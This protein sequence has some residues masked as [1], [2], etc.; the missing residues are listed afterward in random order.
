MRLQGMAGDM[1]QTDQ[2]P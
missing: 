2:L 1:R